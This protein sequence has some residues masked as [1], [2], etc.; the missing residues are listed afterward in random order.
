MSSRLA[1]SCL[2]VAASMLLV[3]LLGVVFIKPEW[4]GSHAAQP[5]LSREVAYD[6]NGRITRI[7]DAGGRAVQYRTS[8]RD[9]QGGYSRVRE[10]PDGANVTEEFDKLGRRRG[11]TDAAGTV[12][13]DFDGLNR[14]TTV[15]R[16]GKPDIRYTCDTP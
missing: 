4:L 16:E 14:L 3:A 12:R 6:A 5:G 2:L 1:A 11:M 15:T 13:Y 9:G 8:A 7:V 10:L